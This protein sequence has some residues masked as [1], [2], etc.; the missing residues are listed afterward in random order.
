MAE[1][2]GLDACTGSLEFELEPLNLGSFKIQRGGG[3]ATFSPFGFW[4]FLDGG[5]FLVGEGP[6]GQI[7]SHPK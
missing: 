2:A 3:T 6:Q 4:W 5:G 7:L 1:V